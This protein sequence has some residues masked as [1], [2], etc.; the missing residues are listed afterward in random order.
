[1]RIRTTC[2]GIYGHQSAT[3]TAEA[4]LL[5]TYY[6]MSTKSTQVA[7]VANVTPQTAAFFPLASSQKQN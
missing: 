6:R 1:M 3:P 5:S 7:N 4:D 2:V